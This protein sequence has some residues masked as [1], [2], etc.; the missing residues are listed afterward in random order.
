MNLSSRKKLNTM[1]K[2]ISWVV[3]KGTVT[4]P[5]I[6]NHIYA[7]LRWLVIMN[8]LENDS[9]NGEIKYD[10]HFDMME[11][12]V[13]YVHHKCKTDTKLDTPGYSIIGINF[14][15]LIDPINLKL[16]VSHDEMDGLRVLLFVTYIAARHV[17]QIKDSDISIKHRLVMEPLNEPYDVGMELLN[18]FIFGCL[19]LIKTRY[20]ISCIVYLH[21]EKVCI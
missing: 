16:D 18:S 3:E 21:A 6:F 10:Q 13:Q 5:H 15:K 4:K 11:W 7:Q 1:N 19:D 14:L 17:P 9:P 8:Y 2:S 12:I 20:V